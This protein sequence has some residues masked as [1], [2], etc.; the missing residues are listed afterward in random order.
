MSEVVPRA[1]EQIGAY[2]LLRE[3]G[4]GA[5]G[6]V[7]EAESPAGQSAAVK[8]IVPPPLL[9]EAERDSLRARFLRE[10]RALSVVDHPNVVRIYEYGEEG[11]YLFLAMEL[12]QGE[13]LR[14]LLARGPVPP[15]EAAELAVQ[16]CAALDAVHHAG[17]V[18]RDVKPE[19]LVLSQGRVKLTDFGVAWMENEATLTRTGGVLGSPAYMSPEQILGKAV[20]RRS[21]LFSAAATLYQ[22]LAGSLPF[23]GSGLMELAHNVIYGEPRPLPPGI[24]YSL[25]RVVQRGLQKSPAARYS[26]ATE[27]AEAIRSAMFRTGAAP[28]AATFDAAATVLEV[29]EDLTYTTRDPASRCTRHP[30]RAAVAH[31]A[32]CR[33]PFCPSCIRQPR[34]PYYCRLHAPVTLFGVPTVRLEVAVAAAAFVLLLLCITSF[35]QAALWK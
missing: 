28:A 12:L 15:A 10:A 31:C 4:R 14:Q 16:L 20:D 27:L 1:G 6:V 21:D 18:H 29:P 19:N 7:F 11:G 17:I 8:I 2:R 22:L 26:T 5:V 13:N 30:G 25:A 23:E 35:G 33:R 24:P 32:A 3:I 9:P 34:P